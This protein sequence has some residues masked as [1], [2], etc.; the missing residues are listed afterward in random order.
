MWIEKERGNSMGRGQGIGRCIAVTSNMSEYYNGARTTYGYW[1]S[2]QDIP[3]TGG[4][5]HVRMSVD[6][7]VVSAS[8]GRSIS[9]VD[10]VVAVLAGSSGS[11]RVT[12]SGNVSR[13]ESTVHS[14]RSGNAEITLEIAQKIGLDAEWMSY[15]P[16]MGT[17]NYLRFPFTA[18]ET[19]TISNH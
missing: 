4:T 11:Y 14:S 7:I 1:V 9:H 3:H 2:N 15:G 17:T 13:E 5:M 19:V 10:D 18:G 6:S 8:V 12:A 16:S